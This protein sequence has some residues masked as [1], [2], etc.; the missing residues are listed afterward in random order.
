LQD[1]DSIGHVA[2]Y[3]R[4]ASDET[5]NLVD[6]TSTLTRAEEIIESSEAGVQIGAVD[7]ASLSNITAIYSIDV[8]NNLQNI[9]NYALSQRGAQ[10]NIPAFM[11]RGDYDI[12]NSD[13]YC[14]S[15]FCSELV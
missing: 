8:G 2:L 11:L 14:P 15:F 13:P 3:Y 4:N 6:G 12:Y 9:L 10:Y 7:S 5:V 1:E